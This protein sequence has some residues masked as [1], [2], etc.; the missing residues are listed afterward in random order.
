MDAQEYWILIAKILSICTASVIGRLRVGSEA[1][2]SI[3]LI[4]HPFRKFQS[5]AFQC[6]V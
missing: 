3:E 1:D 5:K 6:L 2:G 4:F